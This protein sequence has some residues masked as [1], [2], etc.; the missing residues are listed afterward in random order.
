MLLEKS[1]LITSAIKATIKIRIGSNSTLSILIIAN[2]LG[3]FNVQRTRLGTFLTAGLT[4]APT[5]IPIQELFM[6]TVTHSLGLQIA[7]ESVQLPAS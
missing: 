6:P 7:Q 1:E 5:R 3:R 4:I 2:R